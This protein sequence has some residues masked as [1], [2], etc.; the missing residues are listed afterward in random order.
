MAHGGRVALSAR[1]RELPLWAQDAAV[2]VGTAA[3]VVLCGAPLGL[4]WARLAPQVRAD[5]AG[6]DLETL[7]IA[8]REG[9]FV[10]LCLTVGAVLG[11]LGWAA[12]RRHGP[13]VVLGLAGGGA[14]AGGAAA[15]VGQVVSEASPSDVVD[16]VLRAPVVVAADVAVVVL[17]LAAV[18]VFALLLTVLERPRR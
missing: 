6:V 11:A 4:L 3:V 2:A 10:L 18:V 5:G 13:G 12:G 17:P 7:F 16:G 9:S 14:L 8:S 15:H 1:W